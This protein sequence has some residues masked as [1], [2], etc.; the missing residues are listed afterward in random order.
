MSHH[1]QRP[2]SKKIPHFE[3][4]MNEKQ[5]QKAT[6]FMFS[7]WNDSTACIAF[8]NKLVVNLIIQFIF[9]FKFDLFT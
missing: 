6:E 5:E 9:A 1:C 3:K 4:I 7:E 2:V 8:L